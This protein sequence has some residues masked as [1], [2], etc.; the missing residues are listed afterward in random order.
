[1][2]AVGTVSGNQPRV[3]QII[4][5]SG[6][7]YKYGT[8]VMLHSTNGAVE[9]WD[10]STVP[11]IIGVVKTFGQNLTTAGVAAPLSYGSVL[12]QS[13]AKNIPVGQPLAYGKAMVEV[14]AA[15]TLFHGQVGPAQTMAATNVG[16]KCSIAVDTDGHWYVDIGNVST[17]L[18]AYPVGIDQFDT[19]GVYF[20]FFQ[21]GIVP[22]I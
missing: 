8:P 1:M 9:A 4:E 12:N 11:G 16:I 10:G 18:V 17:V 20:T 19:R 7:T 13:A 22:I 15:D 2:L 21:G 14:A 6:Q 5:D 3:V